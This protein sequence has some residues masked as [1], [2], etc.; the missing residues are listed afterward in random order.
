VK[1]P[2]NYFVLAGLNGFE[3]VLYD[4]GFKTDRYH[5]LI[6]KNGS[7]LYNLIKKKAKKDVLR[8]K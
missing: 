3:E 8:V 4:Q 2:E 7:R 6:I 5:L 1:E